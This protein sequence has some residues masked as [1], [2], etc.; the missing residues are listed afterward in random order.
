[1]NW[2]ELIDRLAGLAGVEPWY[3]DLQGRRHETTLAAKVLVLGAL[4]FDV[5]SIAAVR[6]AASA[7]EE[8]TW[9]R[10]LPP[11]IV[12]RAEENFIDLFL[13][14]SELGR[15]WKYDIVLETGE[16]ISGAFQPQQLA[17]LGQREI[18]GRALEHRR[19]EIPPLPIGYHKIRLASDESVESLLASVPQRCHLPRGLSDPNERRWGIATHLY[20]VRSERNWGVGDFDDLSR[21]VET[22]GQAGASAVALNPFHALFPASPDD[23]SPY[24]PSSRLFLNPL[25]I[26]VAA[27]PFAD[28]LADCRDVEPALPALRDAPL[29]DYAKV[30]QAKQPAFEALFRAFDKKAKRGAIASEFE[31]FVTAEGAALD[32]FAAFSALQEQ[33]GRRWQQW[34]EVYRRSRT[35]A[36]DRFVRQNKERV[37]FHRYLQ[38]LADRQ[39][40]NAAASAARA[41]MEIGLIRDLAMG[42]NPDGADAWADQDAYIFALRC[43]APPDDFAPHGQEWGVLALHP[44]RLK[45]NFEPFVALLRANMHH[46]GGLRIDHV[47]GLQRQFLVPLSADPSTGCYVRYP[48]DELLGLLALESRRNSVVVVGEDLGTV[49][50]GF[51]ERMHEKN[52]LGC[53]IL[54][55]ERARDGSFKNP[56][57]Y[58]AQAAVSAATHDLPTLAG[59]WEGR[60]VEERRRIGIYNAA[61]ATAA[62]ADRR[63]DCTRLLDALRR[64][65]FDAG[66]AGDEMTPHLRDAIHAFLASSSAQLF[67]AQLDDLTGEK[68]QINMPGTTT[69][70]ANWR[71][72]LSR[73]LEDAQLSKTL[74][75]LS[76]I[77]SERGRTGAGRG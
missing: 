58:R 18:E 24:S 28:A 50:E 55:F 72:K 41:G 33:H 3:F 20:A 30:W 57:D 47:I 42:I 19:L 40:K 51:P 32:S 68:E 29:V 12:K 54:Y 21:L 62:L 11:S 69:Q 53:T 4:G 75:E 73:S 10:W 27:A 23:A 15:S 36:V 26:D 52:I 70:Y 8:E 38:F 13:P 39:L 67:L 64:A 65:G 5:S 59:F 31:S 76:R 45:R 46:A 61:E 49:P 9:R 71:R 77:C 60:D 16:A 37:G 14:S 63:R 22:A 1:M 74:R 48:L 66:D 44:L 6:A 34:P 35:P 56:R 7:M 25:Y 17:L 43:G 2:T